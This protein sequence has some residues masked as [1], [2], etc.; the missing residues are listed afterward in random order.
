MSNMHDGYDA[1]CAAIAAGVAPDPD[2]PIDQWAD[3][4]MIIPQDSGASEYGPYRTN[5]TPHAR[6]IMQALS[7]AHACK[8][9]VVM[10]ASQM[11]KTQVALN[12]LGA[13]IHQAPS[14]F[15][16][17]VPTGNLVKRSS[18]RIDKTIAAV[19][20]LSERV[21]GKRSRD[22]SN[23]LTTKEFKGGTLHVLTAGAAANLSEVSAR[24]VMYDE[25]DR[26]DANVGGEGSPSALAEARQTT[27]EQNRKTYYPSSPTIEGESPIATLF[28]RGTQREALADCLHCGCAQPLDFERLIKS[29][30]GKSAMYPCIEC[31][32]LHQESDK[33]RMF[34]RGAWSEGVAGDGETESYTISQ[35]FLPYGWFPWI[36]LMRKYE[37]AKRQLD[38]GDDTEM[39]VFYN[40]RLAKCW[41]R[42]KE[43]A[44]YDE[45]MARAEPYRLGTMPAKALVIT[46]A[47]D[48]QNDRLEFKAVA[49]G[50]GMECWV[51]DYQVIMGSPAELSTWEK[52]DQLLLGRYRHAGSGKML[53][54]AC[55]FIDSGGTATQE[56]YQFT[57]TRRRRSVFAIK[58]SSRPNKPILSTKPTLV[59]V[60]HRGKLDKK[61]AQLWFIGTDTAKDYLAARWKKAEGPGAV[62]FSADLSEEYYKQLTAEYRSTVYKR[63]KPVSI[64]EKKQAD[65]NEAGD[66]MVYNLAAAHFAG[67]HK[68][69]E[70]QWRVLREAVAVR[71]NDLFSQPDKQALPLDNKSATIPI[72]AAS[73]NDQQPDSSNRVP[74]KAP[75]AP[76][77]FADL[78]KPNSNRPGKTGVRP[79]GWVK[80]W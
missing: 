1:V 52:A 60:N 73:Q 65:R 36:G 72:V 59:D 43:Q 29:E 40:T 8:T 17:I 24:Y 78:K 20:V 39:V 55:A 28:S 30:D 32:A 2:M 16:W 26:S 66:L 23:N 70:Y 12:F 22:A 56:V 61:G 15:L 18:L 14:N 41:A 75:A 33:K 35:M 10:G 74:E 68:K 57:Y 31:G 50:E 7:P 48:T 58:G 19:P 79:G 51:I 63:G 11:L 13:C 49:W 53:N 4:H 9:V 3:A 25:I 69:N 6:H 42:Q 47:I 38:A 5:R 54:I 80:S 67:L 62:H 77:P 71:E 46:A 45:L 76:E 37:A 34:E 64:W 21:A 44:K 27:Y